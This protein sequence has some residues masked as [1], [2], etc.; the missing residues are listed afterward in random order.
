MRLE[1]GMRAGRES[2]MT[3]GTALNTVSDNLANSNTT[4]FKDSR[5]EFADIF[6][7]GNGNL[8][9]GPIQTGNGVMSAGI[10]QM[11]GIQGTI[12]P[13]GRELDAAIQGRGW[14]VV[15]EGEDTFYTR[16]G[17]FTS[18]PEGFL[19]T[20]SGKFVLGFTEES[21]E[22]AVPIRVNGV[23]GNPQATENI[24]IGGNLNA[25]APLSPV[26][27]GAGATFNEMRQASSFTTTVRAIDSLGDQKDVT[28][29]FYQTDNLNWTVQAVVD[30]ETIGGQAGVPAVVGNAQMVF[31]PNGLQAEGAEAALQVNA[32]WAGGAAAGNFAI[33]LGGF[34]GFAA[35][36]NISELRADGIRGGSLISVGIDPQG[37]VV[38]V[39]DSGENIQVA[40]L[41]LATFNAPDGLQ[42]RGNNYFRASETSGEA[43]IGR[44]GADG[45]GS[46]TGQSLESSTVDP[47]REFVSLIQYQQGYRAGS[48]VIQAM[49]ELITSTIQ[50]A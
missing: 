31:G 33:D 7:G 35:G 27:P 17:N 18:N 41:A 46:I 24:T 26:I 5:V 15:N 44:S 40:Q 43:E 38:G 6:A 47:A 36:S 48:Q 29:Y 19:V 50:L 1:T 11:H 34:T 39:L 21:P 4:G 30:S 32:P 25:S 14:F 45:F 10:F 8:F 37:N 16:A 9:G 20:P 22:V 23:V 49:S 42:R 28:L 13:T 2:L 3:H 12:A